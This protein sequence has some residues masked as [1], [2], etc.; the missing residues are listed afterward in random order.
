MC[1]LTTF[2]YSAMTSFSAL[3]SRSVSSLAFLCFFLRVEHF[4]ERCLLDLQHDVAE[5][6]DQAAIGIVGEARIV[7]ALGQRLNA[8]VVQAEI[9]NRVHH[10]RHGKLRA[11]AHAH[12]QRILASAKLLALQLLRA[13]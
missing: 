9:Q 7:A 10:A 1:F 4:F 6:L 13:A 11:R 5:H 8:L 2:L 3:A 12:Q